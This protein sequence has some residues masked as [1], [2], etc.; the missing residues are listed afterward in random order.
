MADTSVEAAP[1][2]TPKKTSAK[3]TTAKKTATTT[4]AKANHPPMA[5][6]VISAIEALNE[7]KGSSLPAI[8]KYI[9]GQYA[10]DIEKQAKNIRKAL[11]AAIE[12]EV[13]VVRGHGNGLNNRF[14]LGKAASAPKKTTKKPKATKKPVAKKSTDEKVKKPK[15][16][17]AKKEEATVKKT[18]KKAAAKKPAAAA[19]KVAKTTAKKEAKPSK[20]KTGGKSPVAAKAPKPKKSTA[21]K[22]AKK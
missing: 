8:K 9:V 20:A 17:A 19:K 1:V 3:K 11:K 10:L 18:V 2:A 14:R 13:I 6:M 22:S 16:V 21:V 7:K 5:K 4:V 15:V 12:K